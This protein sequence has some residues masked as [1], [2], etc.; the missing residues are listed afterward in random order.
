MI[1]YN[2]LFLEESSDGFDQSQIFAHFSVLNRNRAY[3]VVN[4]RKLE[5]WEDVFTNKLFE[6]KIFWIPVSSAL[7]VAYLVITNNLGEWLVYECN[8]EVEQNKQD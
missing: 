4:G 1:D 6:I 7:I 5:F 3:K 2:F 8:Q